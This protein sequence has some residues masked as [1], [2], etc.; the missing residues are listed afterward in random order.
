MKIKEY[1]EMKKE[2]IKDDRGDSTGAFINFVREQ[3][4]LDPEPRNMELAKADIPRHLWDN[5]NTPDLEQSE[6]LR[7]G[8]TL[9]DWDVTFRR[10]N[11]EGG[12]IGFGDGGITLV[13]NKSKNVVGE[14]LRLFNQGKLYHLRIGLD[15]K[16]YYGSKEKLTKIFNKRRTAGGDVMSRLEKAPKPEG[17]LTKKQFLKFLKENNIKSDNAGS[18]AKNHDINTKP[19]PLQKN[20][21]LYDTSQ[22]TP[23]KIEQI[24]KAQVKSGVATKWA[25]DKFPPK[26][27]SELHKPRLKAIEV[28]GGIPKH[29]PH[30]GTRET[31]LSHAGDIWN[32]KQKITG[33][34]LAYAPKDVN[35]EMG[36]P[37]KLDDKISAATE[38]MEKIKKMNISP[39]H[40]KTLLKIQDNILIRL[41]DQSQGFKKVLLSDGSTYGGDRLTI[42]PFN[43]F[44]GWTEVEIDEFVKKW[45]DKKIITEEMVKKNPKLKVTS[46]DEVENIKKANFFEMNR[47]EALKAASKIS[48]KE[49]SKI[50]K[51]INRVFKKVDID[52]TGDLKLKAQNF[53]RSARNKGQDI[54][55]YL[56]FKTLRKPG[57]AG[58]AALDYGLFHYLFGVPSSEA[59]LGASGWLTKSRPISDTILAQTQ[60][61]SFMDEMNQKKEEE[62]RIENALAAH[63]LKKSRE[64]AR[65]IKPFELDFS[66]PES[67]A[68]GGMAG[69]R[70]PSAIPPESGP[71]SQGLASLKKYGSYY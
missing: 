7:P 33:D 40:K 22:F 9:E 13:K 47:K 37:G 25:R 34:V 68:G 49:Q 16:N 24:Q 50:I 62:E 38:K 52:L 61:M 64:T 30:T 39:K 45:K 70:R 48:K 8:E 12:R 27:K 43:E 53:L 18:F 26:T 36:K 6:F 19:N 42:D 35:I 44:P 14:N 67:F 2:L 32:P 51:E 60:T 4:A 31:H 1:N 41:A 21:N 15:K 28:G 63:R 46:P 65:D 71:Q 55:K 11:A 20:T 23:E 58:V 54:T 5:F 69:I 56:P 57:M 3:R 17:W 59:A 29:S 10:P 66:L